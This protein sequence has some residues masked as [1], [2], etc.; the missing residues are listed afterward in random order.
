[1][2]ND[3]IA[4]TLKALQ[5]LFEGIGATKWEIIINELSNASIV[6]CEYLQRVQ[7]LIGGMG[8]MTDVYIARSNGFNVEEDREEELNNQLMSLAE[9][10]YQQVKTTM[11]QLGCS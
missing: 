8:S 11:V 3:G 10:L 5:N 6:D 1:M 2:A 9:T 4:E 7:S